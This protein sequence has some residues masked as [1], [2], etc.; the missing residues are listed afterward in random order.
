MK[1]YLLLWFLLLSLFTVSQTSLEDSIVVEFPEKAPEFPGGEAALHAYL[2]ENLTFDEAPD[3]AVGTI[4]LS[5][6]V[7][8]NGEVSDVRILR[9]L[10]QK[11]D[12]T[13][14]ELI[15]NMPNWM[16]GQNHGVAVNSRMM[17]PLRIHLD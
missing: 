4:Y 10:S 1:T 12:Q 13:A 16:P 17:L 2:I 14:R 6:V 11:F 5:F 8:A 9:G 3:C 15:L 7:L